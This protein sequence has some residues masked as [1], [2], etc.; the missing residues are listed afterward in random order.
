MMAARIQLPPKLIPVFQGEARYRGSHGG[1][2][3]G[4]TRSFALMTAVDGYRLG[5]A[6]IA[7]MMLCAREHLN[8]LDESSMEEVKQAIASEPWLQAYYEIGEKYIRSRD[9]NIKYGFTGLRHNLD[10]IKSKARILR[11]WVDEA[12][13]VSE[14]AWRKLIPT[15]RDQDT[16][17]GW[18][19]EI[20]ATWNP[21][22]ESS[23]TN[24]RFRVNPPDSSKITEMNWE[25][26]P[27]F[28]GVLNDERLQD[29]SKRPDTYDHIWE[30]KY[31]V[32]TDAQV[33]KGLFEIDDFTVD[34]SFDGPYLG[35]DFGFS[36]DPTAAIQSYI[37]DRVLYIRREAGKKG[38]EL[39]ATV[40]FLADRIPQIC[41]H[42]VRA[43]SARPESISYLKNHGMPRCIA[44]KKGPGSVEDGIAFIKSFDK[45]VIHPDCP[46]TAREFR[47]YSYKVDRLSGDILPVLSDSDNHYIDGLRYSLEPMIRLKARPRIRAL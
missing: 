4:K 17:K 22:L 7:G 9:G 36:Q 18:Q 27:W 20:W 34:S 43:D 24:Q 11:A 37:K 15:V 13:N 33:F 6:G 35:L 26:N 32:I 40:Q 5:R 30:G 3:S 29:L 8:S 28:P 44:A 42:T 21:E 39:D 12:E 47:T 10:G 19:S 14:A 41:L 31:L 45:V 2:G 1:R 25:D 46:E 38:L 23:A 16:A